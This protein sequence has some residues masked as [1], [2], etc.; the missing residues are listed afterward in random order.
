MTP[1]SRERLA[2]LVEKRFAGVLGPGELEELSK[3]LESSEE[4]REL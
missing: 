4:A 2:V 3:L 1:S